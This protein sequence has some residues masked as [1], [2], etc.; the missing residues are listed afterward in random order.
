MLAAVVASLVFASTA[1]AA[2]KIKIEPYRIAPSA[3]TE[4]K[5]RYLAQLE[6]RG[7]GWQELRYELSNRD[8][9]LPGLPPKRV[10]LGK[11]L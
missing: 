7:T 2:Q 10:L 4:L 5:Q 3:L 11:R 6:S 1:A 9:M 8:L